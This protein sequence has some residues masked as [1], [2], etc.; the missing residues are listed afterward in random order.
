M[1]QKNQIKSRK[2]T[3]VIA[4]LRI[5][6]GRQGRWARVEAVGPA[7][8]LES[9]MLAWSTVVAVEMLG[10]GQLC[11]VYAPTLHLPLTCVFPFLDVCFVKRDWE[12]QVR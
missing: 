12:C 5:D 9:A 2:I 4:L 6:Q 3:L 1:F 7:V 10:N 8:I 11:F